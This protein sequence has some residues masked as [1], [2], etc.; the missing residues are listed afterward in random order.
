[1][2]WSPSPPPL[3]PSPPPPPLP[4][5]SSSSAPHMRVILLPTTPLS[6][7][8]ELSSRHR[9]VHRFPCQSDHYK[10][11]WNS[12][13]K[14][15]LYSS[16]RT[17]SLWTNWVSLMSYCR[18]GGAYLCSTFQP[19]LSKIHVYAW[20][21]SRCLCPLSCLTFQYQPIIH[22]CTTMVWYTWWESFASIPVRESVWVVTWVWTMESCCVHSLTVCVCVCM[23]G[24][25]NSSVT[26][27]LLI[28]T[29]VC[30]LWVNGTSPA[31]IYYVGSL[32]TRP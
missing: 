20:S 14:T 28:N 32:F 26:V 11:T 30:V 15:L 21:W 16:T 17:L 27:Y 31:M 6:S 1:M 18:V 29:V 25:D 19:F 13:G 24:V 9:R 5:F 3:P 22:V 4:L 8:R 12:S 2:T 10:E 7:R 23:F